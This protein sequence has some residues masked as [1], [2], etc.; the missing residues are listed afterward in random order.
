LLEKEK[1]GGLKRHQS[2][3]GT[4]RG[5]LCS[6]PEA[7][8]IGKSRC[9]GDPTSTVAIQWIAHQEIAGRCMCDFSGKLIAWL[10]RNF[11]IMKL[12]A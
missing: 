8:A 2:F 5:G 6:A 7:C 12:A 9:T 11:P 1:S 10:D 4:E 3:D